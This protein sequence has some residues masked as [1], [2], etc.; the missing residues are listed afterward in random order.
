[1]ALLETRTLSKSFGGLRA[2]QELDVDVELKGPL[3][4]A[5]KNAA[6]CVSL[7]MFPELANDEVDYVIEKTLEWDKANS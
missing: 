6:S 3:T 1:M 7:P 5:E 2:I 4:H